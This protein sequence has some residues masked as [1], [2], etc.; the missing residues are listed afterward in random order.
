MECIR[1]FVQSHKAVAYGLIFGMVIFFNCFGFPIYNL[2]KEWPFFITAE[3]FYLDVGAAIFS[4]ALLAAQFS[5]KRIWQI[6]LLS[7]ALVCG[8]LAC[9]YF[10][11]FGEASNTYNFTLPN[12]ALHLAAFTGISSLSW[13]YVAKQSRKSG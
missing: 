8:G 12:I 1:Q 13:W 3:Y 9:R 10:L 7:A 5:Q 4:G 11:E 6:V 2:N